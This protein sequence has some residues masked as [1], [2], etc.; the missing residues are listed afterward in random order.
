MSLVL[1]IG[2][3]VGLLLAIFFFMKSSK[4]MPKNWTQFVCEVRMQI[5]GFQALLDDFI[6]RPR[7]KVELYKQPGKIALITGGNRGIG[8][9]IVKKL[10]E[11][12]IEVILGVRNPIDSR[13]AVEAYLE[14]AKIP[15]ASCKLHYE[16]LDIGNMKSVREFAGKIR[17]KFEKIHLL[18]NNAGVMSVPFKL[19]GEGYE[20]HMAINYYGHFLLTHLLLPQLKAAGTAECKARVVNVSSCVHKIGEIDY[21]DINKVKNYYPADAYNQ[22]KLAQVLFAKYI[23]LIFEEEGMPILSNSLHPGV[24][25]TDLFEHSSTNYIPWVRAL[26]FKNPE[27]GS[28]TVVHA[29]IS[30]KLETRGGCYLSNCR[31]ASS[32]R[33]WNNSVQCEKLFNFTCDTL[34]IE[35]FFYKRN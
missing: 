32:H 28:R 25:N 30:P 16:Q 6:M 5:C 29:A 12:E 34:R 8:L 35:D 26:L 15:V 21:K 1:M 20:S 10:V 22:S 17:T 24:V 7:N 11:C 13:K 27:E 4:E 31:E 33:Y 9:R 18:I 2:L 3:P 19:T 14:H 23:N